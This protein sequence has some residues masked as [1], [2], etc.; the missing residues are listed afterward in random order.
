VIAFQ[1][2]DGSVLDVFSM[3]AD[4]SHQRNLTLAFGYNANPT[5]HPTERGSPTT[6]TRTATT[7]CTS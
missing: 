3:R 4:G 5:G 2:V 1:G 6:H 7:T